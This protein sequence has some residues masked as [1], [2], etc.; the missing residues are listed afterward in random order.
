MN[1]YYF[2]YKDRGVS[3][4]NEV[5]TKIVKD[6][7]KKAIYQYNRLKKPTILSKKLYIHACIR[8]TILEDIAKNRKH[9]HPPSELKHSIDLYLLFPKETRKKFIK[10]INTSPDKERRN[11][12]NRYN[13]DYKKTERAF[14]G[15]TIQRNLWAQKEGFRDFIHKNLIRYAIPLEKYKRMTKNIRYLI[16]FCQ[17]MISQKNINFKKYK[18]SEFYKPCYICTSNSFPFKD[19]K[20]IEDMMYKNYKILKSVKKKIEINY[21]DFSS[22][23]Y[24]PERDVFEIYI[25]KDENFRHQSIL[26]IH[27]LLHVVDYMNRIKK[28]LFPSDEGEYIQEYRVLNMF[29]SLFKNKFPRFYSNIFS[30]FLNL[31]MIIF[32]ET[33]LHNNPNQNL[34]KLYA[35]VYN[36]CYPNA[37]L[38]INR[39]W[40]LRENVLDYPLSFLPHAVACSEFILKS[41]NF[42]NNSKR[43]S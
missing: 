8:K 1:K 30:D 20:E 32:F 21:G 41:T 16:S 42:Q 17:D 37:N 6:A 36:I 19:T 13:I 10:E 40:L 18:Y 27:E 12:W 33:E 5:L 4:D 43:Y 23:K 2:I 29:M 14:I 39:A 24:V 26:L 7:E 35:T 38:K 31:F 22:T 9:P 3:I 11:I 15:L 34:G 28:G 25:S